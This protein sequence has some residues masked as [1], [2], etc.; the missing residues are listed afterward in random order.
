MDVFREADARYVAP[1][2][3]GV[4]RDGGCEEQG[5]RADYEECGEVGA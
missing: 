3:E 5:G 2:E 4:G 1:I